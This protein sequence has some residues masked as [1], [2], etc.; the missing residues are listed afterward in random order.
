[1]VRSY[2][3]PLNNKTFI[4]FIS[5]GYNSPDWFRADKVCS[6]MVA[7]YHAAQ[8][9]SKNHPQRFQVWRYEDF[10]LD[11]LNNARTMYD[12]FAMPFHTSVKKFLET[13]TTRTKGPWFSTFRDTNAT[14]FRWTKDLNFTQVGDIQNDCLEAMNLWGYK[15]A[16]SKVELNDFYPI[17]KFDYD[18]LSVS[19][20]QN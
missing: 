7:D 3:I 9:L 14:I 11:V 4:Y 8:I 6:D 16:D 13:H 2:P 12:F 17:F 19:S 20:E 1:M 5:R 10:G 15:M 18:S